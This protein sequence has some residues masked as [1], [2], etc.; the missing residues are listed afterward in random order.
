MN[1]GDYR[2]ALDDLAFEQWRRLPSEDQEG[3]LEFFRWLRANPNHESAVCDF[4][5]TGRKVSISGCGDHVVSH[6]TDHASREV[7][8]VEVTRG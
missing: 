5:A 1:V 6:W 7:R 4:D 3:L 8:I 2:Y